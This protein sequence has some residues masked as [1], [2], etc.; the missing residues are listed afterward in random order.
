[1]HSSATMLLSLALVFAPLAAALPVESPL[2]ILRREPSAGVVIRQCSRPG[3]LALAYDDGPYQYTSELVDILD[4]AGAKATFF[5]TGTLYGCIYDHAPAVKKA[6]ASGHQVASHTWTHP[7]TF[8]SM[9]PEQLT[10]EMDRLD[11]ALVNILGVKPQYMRPPYLMTGGNVLPTLKELDFNVIT[12]DV[13]SGDWDSK[14]PEE[15]LLRFTRA[16]S[17]GKGH[18]SLMHETYA[19]TVR[20]LT[21]YLI[22]WAK[23]RN[24][25]LVT[26]ADC[27]GDADGAYRAGNFTGSGQTSC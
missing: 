16:G 26:V 11:D 18:I 20:T 13:D 9:T 6:F 14:T 2:E 22:D 25:K 21:P 7:N 12:T 19:S 4:A 17:C 10:G 27:L 23:S 1:M 5:W 8:G 3:V 24:L 15:S